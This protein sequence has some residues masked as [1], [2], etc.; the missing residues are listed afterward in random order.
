MTWFPAC[1]SLKIG[2]QLELDT[3][4]ESGLVEVTPVVSWPR[5]VELKIGKE[6]KLDTDQES[7]LG[8]GTP[9]VSWPRLIEWRLDVDSRQVCTQTE[10]EDFPVQQPKTEVSRLA[11]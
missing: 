3:D 6:P 8:E 7:G 11:S 10:P 9:V 2:K 1:Y 5:L 4:Q